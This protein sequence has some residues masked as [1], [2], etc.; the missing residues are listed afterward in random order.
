MKIESSNIQM[1]S[2]HTSSKTY[3]NQQSMKSW[4]N[5]GKNIPSALKNLVNN[6][7]NDEIKLSPDAL[8]FSRKSR[9]LTAEENIKNL[10]GKETSKTDSSMN[11][12]LSDED[13]RKIQILEEF[14]SSLL[15]RKITIQIPR[16]IKSSEDLPQISTDIFKAQKISSQQNRSL[17]WGLNYE[18]H[19]SFSESETMAFQS[20]GTIKTSDGK[21][22]NFDLQLNMSRTFYSENHLSI[23]AG[24]AL[25]DPLVINYNAPAAQVTSTKFSFD[26]DSD[27]T[28]DQISSLKEG[29]GFLALDLNKD[30]VIN[31]GKELFGTESGNGFEDLSKYD[32][33]NNNW[34]DENDAI[35][36]KLRIWTK[37]NDGNSKLFALGEKGIGAIY[38]GNVSAEFSMKDSK[39][40]H[41][42]QARNAGIFVKESGEVGTVQQVDF[43][44]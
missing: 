7:I 10:Q 24:D 15:H 28:E 27:G 40:E 37:D 4:N 34:I 25:I 13:T 30:G 22:I 26:L 16:E 12:Q 19:E 18:H 31:N 36:D 38:L 14:L 23:K 17:G 6:F 5:T 3:K 33:D 8:E 11:I 42:A 29:S 1:S 9:E 32:T 21:S 41:L 2:N 43:V 44:V 20:S 35:F 39:N